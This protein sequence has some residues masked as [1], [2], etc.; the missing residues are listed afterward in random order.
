MP[1]I[2]PS[3][4][5]TT[6]PPRTAPRSPDGRRQPP[7]RPERPELPPLPRQR[8]RRMFLL[9]FLLV[10]AGATLAGYLYTGMS[11][12]S[13]VI[14]VMRD[15]PVGQQITAA[16][17]GTATVAADGNVATIPGRQLHEV[18]GRLAAVDLRRG[19]L[20]AASEITTA[21]SPRPGQQVVPVSVRASQLPARGLR[22]GDQVLVIPTPGSGNQADSAQPN[23][24]TPLAQ[25]T[26]ATVDQVS[27]PDIEGAVR[28]D[29]VVD[30]RAG[31]ALAKQASTGRIGFV[32]T[33]RG[34]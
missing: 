22:P 15:V 34:P 10:S 2:S 26:P 17:V 20:L 11:E 30:A 28:V 23:G 5:G 32:L 7:E 19:S 1:D 3:S 8:R 14:V 27:A 24:A 21:L 13:S 33:S 12:R 9:A 16:D 4:T 31:P 18:I 25:D 6:S 29:L